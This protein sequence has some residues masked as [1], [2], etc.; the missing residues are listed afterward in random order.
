MLK[1][2][3]NI[4]LNT[5]SELLYNIVAFELAE[6]FV[7]IYNNILKGTIERCKQDLSKR[8]V[9]RRRVYEDGLINFRESAAIVDRL[10]RATTH[11]FPGAY[12]FYKGTHITICGFE[13]VLPL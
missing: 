11:P 10:I 13:I 8:T 4:P 6:G 9:R 1:R 3:F 12:T 7:E 2:K 5:T